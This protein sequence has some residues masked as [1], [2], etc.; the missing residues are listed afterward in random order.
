MWISSII[1]IGLIAIFLFLRSRSISIPA[2]QW[3]RLEL[4]KRM[5]VTRCNQDPELAQEMVAM[6][7]SPKNMPEQLLIC[8]PEFTLL[9]AME[10]YMLLMRTDM[11]R[12][13]IV[14][15]LNIQEKMNYSQAGV[16]LDILPEESTIEDYITHLMDVL[17]YL[18]L[19]ISLHL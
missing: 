16:N 15:F 12:E 19:V 1:I 8:L 10:Q 6:G 14:P 11:P 7:F 4:V 13:D 9:R 18:L 2:P 5:F 17:N 3:V